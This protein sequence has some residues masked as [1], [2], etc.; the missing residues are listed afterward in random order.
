MR[1]EQGGKEETKIPIKKKKSFIT[2]P[3]S[4]ISLGIIVTPFPLY[5]D[6]VMKMLNWRRCL[7]AFIYL[8]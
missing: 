1:S 5:R 2:F 8:S 4:L 6:A 3:K 7:Y